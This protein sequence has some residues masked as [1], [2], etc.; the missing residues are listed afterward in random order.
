MCDLNLMFSIFQN[1][2]P[3]FKRVR[4]KTL[5]LLGIQASNIEQNTKVTDRVN[6]GGSVTS[7]VGGILAVVGAALTPVTFGASLGLTIAGLSVGG[8]G[9]VTSVG[10][11][12]S[13][14][15]VKRAVKREKEKIL[16]ND[17]EVTK[18]LQPSLSRL[19]EIKKKLSKWLSAQQSDKAIPPGFLQNIRIYADMLECVFNEFEK[20]SSIKYRAIGVVG[21]AV[22]VT[23]AAAGVATGAGK[24]SARGVA[25]GISAA[26]GA[27]IGLAAAGMLLD[28]G[29]VGYL[30]YRIHNGSKGEVAEKIRE[31]ISEFKQKMN[32]LQQLYNCTNPKRP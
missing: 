16:E 17:T 23:E 13:D 7:I 18:K 19:V 28:I 11:V 15:K 14:V 3:D 1:Y 4:G 6:L 26:A 20:I 21:A 12:I 9:G 5:E 32:V 22:G 27:S 29:M 8:V 25:T 10:S 31:Y 24:A 30:S 2:Y